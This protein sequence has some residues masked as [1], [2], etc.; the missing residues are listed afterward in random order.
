MPLRQVLSAEHA[1]PFAV[2][3]V[4]VC[5]NAELLQSVVDAD[6]ISEN[7]RLP[8]DVAFVG[9]IASGQPSASASST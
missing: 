6:L 2:K 1:P 5:E 9:V 3:Q 7:L 8:L 4:F